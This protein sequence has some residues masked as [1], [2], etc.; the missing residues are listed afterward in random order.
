MNNIITNNQIQ[1]FLSE[2]A[3]LTKKYNIEICG[4]GCCGS[5]Y[6]KAI[7]GYNF[8]KEKEDWEYLTYSEEQ[9]KYSVSNYWGNEEIYSN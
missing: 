6:I 2:L 3:Q 1:C 4:C 9:E 7:N 8:E 5:P